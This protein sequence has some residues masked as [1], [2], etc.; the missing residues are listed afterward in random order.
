MKFEAI[1]IKDVAKALNL[2]I[3]TVSKA[4]RGSYEISAETQKLV[5][6]YAAKHNYKPNPI[7]QGLRNGSSKSIGIMV[8]NIDNNF[9]SQVI[10]GIESVAHRKDYNVII[11]QTHES[12]E[13]EV[14][15][16]QHMLTRS[17]D[18][19]LVSICAE[20][21]NVGHFKEVSNKGLPIVF[22]DRV[23]DEINTHRVI[24]NNFR[25]AY[26]GT[27]HLI[28][29][30]YK[31]IAHITSSNSLSITLE[32]LEGYMKALEDYNLPLDE[33][34]IKYCT[35]GGMIPEETSTALNELMAL[36]QRPDAVFT[37]SDRLSTTTLS[38]L[39]KMKIKVPDE[40]GMAGFTNSASADIFYPPLTT[41]VQPAFE[42]G[43]EATEK[44]I[45]LIEAKRPVVHFEKKV[46]DAKLYVRESS[47]KV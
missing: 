41:I 7:A 11:T 2:S 13:R 36:E 15:T 30:G 45:Q 1:T 42:I 43:K 19:L 18:G 31:R 46:L 3:S 37:A 9:F 12:Y 4:L 8:T 32:R 38:L 20:T 47:R 5:K 22:F 14:L 10:N 44:L 17:I 6:E 35:H 28:Q 16:L 25:G 26:D 34:L 21:E 40:I 39:H 29:N 27:A 23:T 33:C 24:C